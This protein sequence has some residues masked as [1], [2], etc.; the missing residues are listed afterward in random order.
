MDGVEHP[1]ELLYAR[2]MTERLHQFE[3]DASEELRL[4][5]RAQHIAR[6]QIPRSDYPEGRRGYKQWRSRLMHHHASL[7]S[8]VLEEVGYDSATIERVAT[9][10]RKQGLTRDAEVQALEDVICLVF[11][12]H[13]FDAFARKHDDDKLVDILRKTWAK[14]GERGR[15]AAL[16]LDLS[17]PTARLVERAIE[18]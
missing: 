12:D 2:R 16:D 7:A 15:R 14:M 5:A 8:Q 10:L 18:S 6:W 11:L 13:Y 1:T 9:L 17:G 3:P 4:A